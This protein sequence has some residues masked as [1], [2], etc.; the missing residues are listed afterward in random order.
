EGNSMVAGELDLKLDW[1]QTY[2]GKNG[3][4]PVNAYPD[5][6]DDGWQSIEGAE[7]EV[8]YEPGSPLFLDCSDLESGDDLPED[9]FDG[10]GGPQES[11]IELDDVK[12]G[13]EGEIT[14]SLHLCDN[15]GYLWMF[16]ELADES[17]NGLTEPEASAPGEDPE[18]VELADE[19]RVTLW[20]DDDCD[21]VFD[22]GDED[23]E[24]IIVGGAEEPANNPSLREVFDNLSDVNGIP[25]DGDMASGDSGG[26]RN[27]FSGETQHCIG[28]RW[29]LPAETGNHVQG[30]SLAFDV[31]FYTEQC[32]HNDGAP[33]KDT[34]G[35][36][37]TENLSTGVA[38][39]KVTSSPDGTTGD[40]KNIE[41]HPNWADTSVPECTFG[42]VDPYGDSSTEDDPVGEYVYEL[43]F[44]I[45]NPMAPRDLVIRAF[46]SDN[47][48][49]IFLDGEEIHSY[50]ESQAYHPL[51]LEVVTE[52]DLGVGTHT[53]RV[54][55]TNEPL[56]GS[57]QNPTG[58]AIC[59]HLE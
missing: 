1:Q 59:A 55:V 4:V 31:G 52:S 49:A 34:A 46:G 40:A 14:F 23:S 50:D 21:N 18:V 38:D 35:A 43:E 6:D 19:L 37:E 48:G 57:G 29:E 15:P 9:V 8:E 36:V 25:L 53:L 24:T 13:D 33:G 41:K 16:G 56:D 11:L 2:Y 5:H 3:W 26:E 28:F 27:C 30:D 42:W 44:E 22:D 54:E 10:P 51:K 7:S 45:A 32:R 20:Y 12:P 39:W 47:P 58:L 17:E